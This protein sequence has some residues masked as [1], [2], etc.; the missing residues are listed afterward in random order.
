MFFRNFLRFS[1]LASSAASNFYY[2]D[3]QT[4]AQ[5]DVPC[6]TRD[7]GSP[8]CDYNS[9]R[10]TNGLC[11]NVAQ[12]FVLSRQS[13]TNKEWGSA[14]GCTDLCKDIPSAAHRGCSL[15]LYSFKGPGE[16]YYCADT[17]TVDDSGNLKCASGSDAFAVDDADVIMNKG[18]LASASCALNTLSAI[19]TNPVPTNTSSSNCTASWS[20]GDAV[21]IGA[22][23]GVP[24]GIVVITSLA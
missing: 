9:I 21:A 23:V 13:C 14:S 4:V 16:A 7:G 22:G 8:C 3:G 17:V 1:L 20:H 12:P 18:L 24:L 10:L 6:F 19:A 5:D 2:P 15:P 11:M